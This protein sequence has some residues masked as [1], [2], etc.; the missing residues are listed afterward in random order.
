MMDKQAMADACLKMVMNTAVYKG[1]AFIDYMKKYDFEE[2][3]IRETF[4]E[5][6][7]DR[8]KEETNG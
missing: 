8:F 1:F 2:A 7:K 5:L 4:E 3:D 6:M